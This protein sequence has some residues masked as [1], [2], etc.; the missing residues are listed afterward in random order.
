MLEKIRE[1][2]RNWYEAEAKDR[3]GKRTNDE[4]GSRKVMTVWRRKKEKV[5]TAIATVLTATPEAAKGKQEQR[6]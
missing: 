6:S 5:G 3:N 1:K 4:S 2:R